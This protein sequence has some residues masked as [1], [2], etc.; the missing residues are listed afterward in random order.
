MEACAVVQGIG[1][2]EI[3]IILIGLLGLA[4]VGFAIA[5][6]TGNWFRKS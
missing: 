5:L 4:A 6:L 1:L 3:I 2:S